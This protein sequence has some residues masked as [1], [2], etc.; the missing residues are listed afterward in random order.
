MIARCSCEQMNAFLARFGVQRSL[1]DLPGHLDD[2]DRFFRPLLVLF[3]PASVATYDDA[4]RTFRR[5]IATYGRVVS[6]DAFR[7]HAAWEDARVMTLLAR[8][9]ER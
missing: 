6:E 9:G 7:E 5:E 2:E 1:D 8:Q 3:E 4:H